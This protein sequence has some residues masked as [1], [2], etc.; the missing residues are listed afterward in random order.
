MRACWRFRAH[1][2]AEH[3]LE[4]VN[5]D[6]HEIVVLNAACQDFNRRFIQS[7]NFMNR[8]KNLVFAVMDLQLSGIP[9]APA[10]DPLIPLAVDAN[11]NFVDA[12]AKDFKKS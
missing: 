5:G 4:N 10:E 6:D 8:Q 3:P 11:F 12:A 2:H 9:A 7:G 1:G